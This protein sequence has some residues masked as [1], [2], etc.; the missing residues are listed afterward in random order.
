[1]RSVRR[2]TGPHR[3][4]N[5][6]GS[7]FRCSCSL[8]NRQPGR[9]RGANR[10]W[11]SP[12][13]LT[14]SLLIDTRQ[15]GLV[16]DRWPQVALAAGLAV[17]DAV[18]EELPQS[19]VGLKWPNDV[20]ADGTKV[21]GI[22]VEAPAVSRPRLVLGIGLNVNNSLASAPG[23][24]RQRATSMVDAAGHAFDLTGVL[25]RVLGHVFRR[26]R[27]LTENQAD[28]F[29]DWR[30]ACLLTG[31]SVCLSV[32]TREVSGVCRGIDEEGRLVLQTPEGVE[33]FRT[34][35]V[36]SFGDDSLL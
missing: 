6:S 27:E 24:V 36:V 20:Y 12:G 17:C 30:S 9:G 16:V 18:R 13:A 11:S 8:R 3:S 19:A 35:T 31:R 26:L 14:F 4:R 25:L 33:C 2:T 29:R 1:M 34:G 10:W 23:E 5:K 21:C 7:I 32:G 28:V 22:L 15:F